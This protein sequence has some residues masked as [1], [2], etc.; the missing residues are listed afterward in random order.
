[1]DI[2]DFVVIKLKEK[3]P[4]Y[5][6]ENS[7]FRNELTVKLDK[8]NIVKVCKFLKEDEELEFKLCEDVT[9][10][11]WAK[12]TDRFTVVYHI[13]SL[14]HNFRLRLKADVDESDCSIDTV[15]SV[16]KSA[17]WAEREAYD[18]Y[19]IIFKGHPDLRR[20]YMPE[21]FEF[22]PLR[23]DFPLLGIPGSLPLPKKN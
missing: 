16:W 2:K 5:N 4:K 3:F 1:M 21:E 14:R 10:I 8:K 23:K 17:N 15:S 6:F 7:D 18:M 20:M 22:H 12:R 11:D 9:A 13:F 19:G